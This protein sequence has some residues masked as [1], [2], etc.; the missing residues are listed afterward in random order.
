MILI[1]TAVLRLCVFYYTVIVMSTVYLL[2]GADRQISNGIRTWL[3]REALV[4]NTNNNALLDELTQIRQAMITPV[5]SSAPDYD[6]AKHTSHQT[7]QANFGQA[8]IEH[9]T[10]DIFVAKNIFNTLMRLSGTARR[11]CFYA[12]GDSSEYFALKDDLAIIELLGIDMLAGVARAIDARATD[13]Q[14][15]GEV[16]VVS[17]PTPRECH[18]EAMDAFDATGKRY[19][20][21]VRSRVPN[22]FGQLQSPSIDTLKQFFDLWSG[23]CVDNILMAA[24]YRGGDVARVPFWEPKSIS[25]DPQLYYPFK[26]TA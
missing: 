25:D 3:D 15:A 4:S 11:M 6:L 5:S 17:A 24:S 9:P 19:L 23:I 26:S 21:E 1:T 10:E 12:A 22:D 2:P 14:L 8:M 18:T 13:R 16:Q 20:A 7:R